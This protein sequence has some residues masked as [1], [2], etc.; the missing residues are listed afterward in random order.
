MVAII[1]ALMGFSVYGQF[2]TPPP[3]EGLYQFAVDQGQVLRMNTKT[4]T[5]ERCVNVTCGT[6]T[7]AAK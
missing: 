1:A 3:S 7:T 4:G 6:T 2:Q 5:I